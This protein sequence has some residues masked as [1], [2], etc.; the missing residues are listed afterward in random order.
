MDLYQYE[1]YD[2]YK[3]LQIECN[4]K[5]HDSVWAKEKYIKE[6]CK[7]LKGSK[8]GL[9]HGVRTG[10]EVEYFLKYLPK[11]KIIGTEISPSVMGFKNI[12]VWDFHEIKKDWIRKF[13]FIY[14]NSLD[15]SYNPTKA[16]LN[17]LKCLKKNGIM[18]I[19]HTKR[20][21]ESTKYDPFG[22]NFSELRVY[23]DH[24]FN[25]KAEIID[26]LDFKDARHTKELILKKL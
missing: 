11:C 13:N 12:L 6:I 26:I 20:H 7:Y 22:T 3:K 25:Y 4:R 14:S 18:I 9:C 23:I 8:R 10:K 16:L 19:E 2:E 1:S 24:I 17:W 21:E 5:K 15:H